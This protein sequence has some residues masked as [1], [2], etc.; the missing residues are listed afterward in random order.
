[1]GALLGLFFLGGTLAVMLLGTRV[2]LY[3]FTQNVLEGRPATTQYIQP[4]IAEQTTLER[5]SSL[6]STE[7]ISASSRYAWGGLALIAIFILLAVLAM[8]TI[9]SGV[10]H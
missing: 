1:M 6:S 5:S 4:A 9:M 7:T 3:F 8:I 10:F 2:S